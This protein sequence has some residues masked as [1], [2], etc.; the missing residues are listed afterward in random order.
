M[1]VARTRHNRGAVMVR[2]P[3][4]RGAPAVTRA[5]VALLLVRLLLSVA[6]SLATPLGEA[7]DE[8]DH[9]AYAAYLLEKGELPVGPEM[10]QGKHPPL[11]HALAAVAAKL[12]GGSPDR[13]FLRANPDM[14]FGPASQASNFFVH[15]TAEEWPWRDGVLAMR[16]G[17]GVSILAGLVLVLATFLLG[18]AIWPAR[19]EIALAGAAFAAFLPES[20]FVSGAMSNDMLAAMWATLALWLSMKSA[21]TIHQ[22]QQSRS[23]ES[24]ESILSGTPPPGS[25][26]GGVQSKD[27][28]IPLDR[29]ASFDSGLSP[30]A[31]DAPLR[32]PRSAGPSK[33][34]N[35]AA[36]QAQSA[37]GWVRALLTGVCLGLAFVT[38]ASTGSLAVIVTAVFLLSAW[39]GGTRRWPGLRRLAPGAIQ[40]ALAGAA[41]FAIAAP[42]LWRNWRLYGDPFGW[43]MVLATIDQRQGPLGLAGVQQLLSG[44]WISFW[45]KFG[46]AGHIPLPTALYLIWAAIGAAALVGW[47]LHLVR[48]VP[49]TSEVPGTSPAH[50]PGTSPAHLP[51]TSPA[52]LPGTSP[53]PLPGTSPAPLPGTSP[54]HLPGACAWIVLLGTPLVTAAGIYSY[55]KV[56]LGTDQG[57]LLFPALGPLALLIAGGLH[58]WLG[59]RAA[60]R[61]G[62]WTGVMAGGMA[63][64][65]VAALITGLVQPFSAPPEPRPE[66]IAAAQPLNTRFGPVELVAAA[67]DD[68]AP[69]ELT[70]Y[71]R[72]A[73]PPADDL[74][75]AL[76]LLDADGNLLWEWKRSP[77]AGRFSTDRW[78]VDRAVADTYRPPP[79]LLARTARVEIGVRPFPEGAWLSPASAGPHGSAGP[80]GAG[81]DLL[82][83]PVPGKSSAPIAS[84]PFPART[85]LHADQVA[86]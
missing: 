29:S 65:A 68:P 77:A 4:D 36:H 10:T 30:A 66:R 57:R 70:L 56:A 35:N 33:G 44:W 60:R 52:H 37:R 9:Y 71:W 43:P 27:A 79:E 12:A 7:P 3:M 74:R 85:A 13:S 26:G 1:D 63:L 86:P 16:A 15:T 38:K 14:A 58:A 19:P 83:L 41:A 49:G 2:T 31:Q 6:F 72:A 18:R 59:R 17:R 47:L 21:I 42:W 54:A 46:G 76:R 22:R 80:P 55:S 48:Q 32:H 53:A 73:E 24:P 25:P 75:T 81:G 69:G 67:W 51:G 61:A 45:G 20:L 82:P 50:L 64:I 34:H 8:A 28:A 62:L 39:P 11:Y 84:R 78:P 40:V 5:I 23:D